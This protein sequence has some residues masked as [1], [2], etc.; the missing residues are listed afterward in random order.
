M[1]GPSPAFQF[2]PKDWLSDARVKAMT[3]EEKGVYIDLLSVYWIEDGLPTDPARLSRLLGI[4]AKRFA[5]VWPAIAACFGTQGETLTQKRLEAEKAKQLAFRRQQSEKGKKGGKPRRINK[6]RKPRVNRSFDLV[7]PDQSLSVSVPVSVPS[8]LSHSLFTDTDLPAPGIPESLPAT[9]TATTFA[10]DGAGSAGAEAGKPGNG[11][12]SR[13][14]CD[15]WVDRFTGSAPGGRIG[16]ALKPLV[17]R[18]GWGTVREAWRRYLAEKEPD[19]ASAQDFASKF[20]E[21]SAPAAIGTG[22]AIVARGAGPGAP[23]RARFAAD[24]I[25]EKVA[26]GVER[27]RIERV[28]GGGGAK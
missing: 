18:F 11:P 16:A 21:W 19:F 24:R 2:Y 28:L 13:E 20:G 26:E 14:A 4:E 6:D 27:A 22:Q 1:K 25:D 7:K 10:P 3:F 23:S 5:R 9:A 12:W 15:D 17:H 8:S